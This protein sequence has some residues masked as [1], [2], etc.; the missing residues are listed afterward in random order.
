[1][2]R[3]DQLEQVWA[4]LQSRLRTA[5]PD[6]VYQAWLRTLQP[7]GLEQSVL[8]LKT[9]D[10]RRDWMKRR[11]GPALN[12]AAG[13]SSTSVERV[14]LVS[15]EQEALGA[16]A[17]TGLARSRSQSTLDPSYTFTHFV[18]GEGNR[19]AHAAALAAAE[20]PSQAYNP[21]FIYGPA[22][23][24]KTHL[25]QAIGSYV[26]AHESTLAIRYT[27]VETFTNE[28]LSA[29]HNQRLD[30]FKRSYREMDLLL[31]DDIQILE[32][33]TKTAEE[34]FYTLDA[35]A[36]S[37]AQ[38]V[39]SGSRHP[40]EMP[41][42]E[43]RL[44]ERLQGG[45]I[46]DLH[47]PD[48]Q[49]RLAILQNQ[50]RVMDTAACDTSV[51]EQLAQKIPSNVRVLKGALIRLV[52]FS[53]LTGKPITIDVADTALGAFYEAPEH[54][55][56]QPHSRRAVSPSLSRIHEATAAAFSLPVADLSSTKRTRQ[57]VYARQIAMYLAR[58]LT[59][60]SLP[61]I[62]RAFGG[63]DHTTVLHAHRKIRNE[64]ALSTEAGSTVDAIARSL[65]A[66]Q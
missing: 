8:Y 48:Y 23:V 4:D 34:F 44:R 49:T 47:A 62:A 52:A 13:A 53:S 31:L 36:G 61:A 17:E 66:K 65:D 50:A 3:H 63:R 54:S 5:F 35:I 55:A 56:T 18:I 46:A 60:L 32:G 6:H 14:E 58:E 11:F 42:L 21:L 19:F 2:S 25:L 27:T 9:P 29:L 59:S 39:L 7:L 22:G 45:L 30:E 15:R 10:S 38:I 37:G 64:V 24:G 51:L 26:R 40:C 28:F 43:S 20:M 41:L 57:V 1:L 33:K 16:S 12:A